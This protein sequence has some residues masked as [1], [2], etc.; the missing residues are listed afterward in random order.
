MTRPWRPAPAMPVTA[1][2]TYSISMPPPLTCRQAG[3][4][5]YRRGWTTTV[6]M[7]T[8]LGR[9]QA[10]YITF[11]CGRDYTTERV[12]GTDLI[13]FKFRPGQPCFAIHRAPELG[14]FSR[15]PGD[16]RGTPDGRVVVFKRPQD[17][18]DD[19]GE[20]QARLADLAQKG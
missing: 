16:W 1:Y 18:V 11:R 9:K 3:C 2:Q 17:W 13:V 20:H 4:V 10:A 12:P 14:R 7:S 15:R 8:E 19:F 5:A 6:D